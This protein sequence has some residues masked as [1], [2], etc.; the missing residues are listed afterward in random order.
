MNARA[1][2]R[3]GP[4]SLGLLNS[5]KIKLDSVIKLQ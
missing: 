2:G 1:I 3:P 5:N 4:Q